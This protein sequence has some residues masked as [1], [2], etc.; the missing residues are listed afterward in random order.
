M[1][2]RNFERNNVLRNHFHRAIETVISNI[3]I[4]FLWGNEGISERYCSKSIS[5]HHCKTFVKQKVR[6]SNDYEIFTYT[7][8][9]N[10]SVSHNI[11]QELRYCERKRS[12]LTIR[13]SKS[14]RPSA[15]SGATE[16]FEIVSFPIS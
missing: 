13:N 12:R 1:C 16:I 11:P 9:D 4:T 5:R 2:R 6:V 3:K 8:S 10:C 14:I 15:K 7:E